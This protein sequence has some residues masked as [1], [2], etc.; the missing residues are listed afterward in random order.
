MVN[1][2]VPGGVCLDY[3]WFAR[4]QR[5]KARL[6]GA[7]AGAR[8]VRIAAMPPADEP[9]AGGEQLVEAVGCQRL[10]DLDDQMSFPTA[11]YRRRPKAGPAAQVLGRQPRSFRV[12]FPKANWANAARHRVTLRVLWAARFRSS[13]HPVAPWPPSGPARPLGCRAL[14]ST[15]RHFVSSSL[16]RAT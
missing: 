5:D 16:M 15:R 10:A 9:G 6:R 11:Q 3:A 2:L 12:A 8:L 14:P 7:C 13:A 1:S 4:A